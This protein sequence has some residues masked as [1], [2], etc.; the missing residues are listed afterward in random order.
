MRWT[1]VF[2]HYSSEIYVRT[3]IATKQGQVHGSA[4]GQEYKSAA[5]C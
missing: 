3:I 1:T 5:Q 4:K 2:L